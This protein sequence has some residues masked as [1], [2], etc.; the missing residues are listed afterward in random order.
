MKKQYISRLA[1]E[2][3]TLYSS[4]NREIYGHVARARVTP[5]VTETLTTLISP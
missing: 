5:R 4:V 2:R 3:M 1:E